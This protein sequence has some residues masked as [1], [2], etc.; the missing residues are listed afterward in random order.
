MSITATESAIDVVWLRQLMSIRDLELDDQ[1]VL[2]K[3]S[4]L[5]ELQPGEELNVV[6]Q[7]R[8]LLYLIA[9]KLKQ[10]HRSQSQKHRQPHHIRDGCQNHT[11]SN[12]RVNFIAIQNNRNRHTGGGSSQQINH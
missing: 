11:A 2:A 12:R 5:M 6:E 3:K 10:K 9:K 1:L 4:H 8:W 7:H